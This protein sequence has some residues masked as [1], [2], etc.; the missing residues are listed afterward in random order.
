MGLST[1][2]GWLLEPVETKGDVTSGKA[3][4]A[5]APGKPRPYLRTKNVFDG[6]IVTNDV[7]TMPM[8]DAEFER[9]R[10]L[11]GDVLLNE[12]QSLELVGRCAVYRDESAE[13]CAMQNQLLRFRARPGV[14]AEFAAHLFR[15]SQQKGT[16]ARIALQT[17]SIAHLGATRLEKLKLLWPEREAEQ[18]AIAEALCGMDRLIESLETLIAKKRAIQYATM[19]QLLTGRTRLPGFSGEEWEAA[20]LDHITSRNSGYW[21]A[22]TASPTA[23]HS[24]RVIRAG[25]ISP[26]GVLTGFAR[27]FFRSTELQNAGCEPGDV[28]ITVSGNGLGKT[29]L[30]DR[31]GMAGSNFVR[32]LK[33]FP[34]RASG[35]FVAFSLRSA[36]AREQLARHTATSAYPNLL[37]S[38]FRVPWLPLPPLAEQ[39]AIANILSDMD[40]EIRA[41]KERRVKTRAIKQGAMQQLL[42]GRIRLPLDSHGGP[43]G[44]DADA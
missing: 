39:H 9:Y 24:A 26:E 32:I 4:A 20:T 17:T 42:T 25:D 18:G 15:Y 36:V 43:T 19:Q 10:V 30:V 41:L 8:T 7:L 22:S 37:P 11:P 3:L 34:D 33:A 1:P 12:G 14:S 23:P 6:R 2:P 27:R 38:F 35:P 28:V 44:E 21:G 29:W 31:Q 13:P 40:E 16:F 5:G